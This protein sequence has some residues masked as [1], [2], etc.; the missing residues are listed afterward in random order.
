MIF[1]IL[2]F[3]TIISQ[4]ACGQT[5]FR[6]KSKPFAFIDSVITKDDLNVEFLDFVFSQDVQ[7]ILLRFQ[8]SMAENKEWSEE[9]FSKNYKAGEGL[10][11]HEKFGITKE[12]YQKIKDIDKSPP[13]IVVKSTASIKRN[14]TSGILTF[15]AIKD[16]V[17]FFEL[18]KID[19][20]KEALIFNNDT[21]P[22]SNDVNAPETT[23][24]GEWHGYAWKKETSNLGDNDDLKMDKLVSK[25]IEINFGRVKL[26]NKILFRLKYKDIDKGQINANLD[27]ACYL[28]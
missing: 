21:I 17:K 10:P 3:L 8:K 25:I 26:N 24:F 7:E 1:R 28:N 12:E 18:L 6:A 2:L 19:F 9:Y 20:K 14:K 5:E 27:V 16:D 22:F 15:T 13:T 4:A 11:Y 23:P